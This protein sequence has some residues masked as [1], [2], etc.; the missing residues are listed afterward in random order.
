YTDKAMPASYPEWPKGPQVH[1]YLVEYAR[2]HGLDRLIRFNTEVAQM[3]RR[4]DSRPGWRLDLRGPGGRTSED[5]DF[6]A[7]CT[8]QFNEPQTLS[9]RG[10][11]AFKAQGGRILH[12]SQ[13]HD[14]GLAQGN[15]VVVMWGS[16]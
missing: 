1:A 12:C 9:L 10:E 11:E 7:I 15:E 4:P 13:Y 8:G 5:F 3:N 6:V 14:D 2:D 16:N